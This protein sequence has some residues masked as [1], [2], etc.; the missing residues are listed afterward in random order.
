MLSSAHPGSHSKQ[1]AS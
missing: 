1:F